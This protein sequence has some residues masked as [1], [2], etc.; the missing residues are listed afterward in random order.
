MSLFTCRNPTLANRVK[1]S[2]IGLRND[3]G[4]TLAGCVGFF[5]PF[6]CEYTAPFINKYTFYNPCAN[7]SKK[8][9]G[10]G[11]VM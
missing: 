2:V 9:V 4:A 1:R 8:R 7:I 5:L 10:L 6:V 3:D 11:G